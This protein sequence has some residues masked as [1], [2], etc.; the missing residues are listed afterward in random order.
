MTW[1]TNW[2]GPIDQ[3]D[4]A[5]TQQ[6]I[7]LGDYPV[8]P[9]V[10]KYA[11][12]H[13]EKMLKRNISQVNKE[14]GKEPDMNTITYDDLQASRK[15]LK[16]QVASLERKTAQSLEKKF[17]LISDDPPRSEKEMVE[18]VLAGRYRFRT[19]EEMRNNPWQ[20]DVRW[21]S[22]DED[23]VGFDATAEKLKDMVRPAWDAA[24]VLP[25]DQALV[26]LEIL[27]DSVKG[28]LDGETK[29]KK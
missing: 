28:L 17:G 21:Q 18:R 7:P 27:R 20:S 4:I 13:V 29:K 12:K 15:Y 22:V 26:Q 1:K 10:Q 25:T 3:E 9:E 8:T 16:D 24:N 2:L 19:E 23:R 11:R 6:V 14:A 5:V